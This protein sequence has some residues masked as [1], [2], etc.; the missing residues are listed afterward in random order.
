MHVVTLPS[1]N[2]V[3]MGRNMQPAAARTRQ[4]AAGAQRQRLRGVG[5]RA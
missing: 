3:L 4:R 2:L 5:Q 1:C